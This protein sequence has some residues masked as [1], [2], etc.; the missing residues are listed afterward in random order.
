MWG[1]ITYEL[2]LN[3]SSRSPDTRP[4]KPHGTDR[5]THGTAPTPRPPGTPAARC[6]FSLCNLGPDPDQRGALLTLPPQLA[7]KEQQRWLRSC[8]EPTGVSKPLR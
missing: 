4:A 6:S 3:P 7:Q 5:E 2:D 1:C 8:P